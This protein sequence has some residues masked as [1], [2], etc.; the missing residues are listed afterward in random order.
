MEYIKKEVGDLLEKYSK[1]ESNQFRQL[2]P[3]ILE[4]GLDNINLSMFSEDM[5][6]ELLNAVG[7]EYLKRGQ[8]RESIKT[9]TLVRNREKLVEIG[10]YHLKVGLFVHAVE[11]YQ[12]AEERDKLLIAGDKALEGGHLGEAIKAFKFIIKTAIF[13]YL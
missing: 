10:D 4:K 6:A 12:A 3:Y 5:K 7:E 8:V 13:F 1:D 11:A 9:F 2:V